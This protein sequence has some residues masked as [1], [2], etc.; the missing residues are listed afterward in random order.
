MRSRFI[1][2]LLTAA[3]SMLSLAAADAD[4]ATNSIK[5]TSASSKRK[6]CGQRIAYARRRSG[7]GAYMVPPPPPYIPG[8]LPEAYMK[9]GSGSGITEIAVAKKENPYKKYVQTPNGD[10]PEPLQQRKGVSTWSN[11]S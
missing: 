2:G 6:V 7:R 3:I 1:A 4:A 11:R 8:V 9:Y 5:R 10:A